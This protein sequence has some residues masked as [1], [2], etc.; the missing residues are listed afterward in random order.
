MYLT[1]CSRLAQPSKSSVA[2]PESGESMYAAARVEVEADRK[3]EKVD[4]TERMA[5]EKKNTHEKE[6]IRKVVMG[7]RKRNED[8]LGMEEKQMIAEKEKEEKVKKGNGGGILTTKLFSELYIS[9]LTAKAIREMNY[10]HL[11]EVILAYAYIFAIASF[12]LG[13][14]LLFSPSRCNYITTYS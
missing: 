13:H 6:Q 9:E 2:L 12:F 8:E 7:K 5:R 11:T 4:E 10:S 3:K 14:V 1:S